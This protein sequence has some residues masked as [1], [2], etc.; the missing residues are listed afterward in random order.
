MTV[1]N[2]INGRL[3]TMGTET[4]ERVGEAIRAL[5]YR[6]DISARGLRRSKLL[7]IGMIIV[8]ESP[9]YLADGYT[10]QIV[11]GLGNF[12][13]ERGYT[14]QLEGV[15]ARALAKSSL[16]QGLRTDGLCLMLSGK[17]AVKRDQMAVL[18]ELR[19]PL[20]IFLESIGATDLDACCIVAEDR[21]GGRLLAQHLIERGAKRTV[22]LMP[23]LNYWRALYARF[24]GARH[25]YASHRRTHSLKL[26]DCG[27]GSVAAAQEALA[28][29]IDRCGM[30][31]AV[32]GAN[33]QAGIAAL[34]LLRS[35]GVKVPDQV[36][37]T[38]FNAFEF[39]DFSRPLL[40]SVKSP[41]YEMGKIGGWELL[42]RLNEGK[43]S[44]SR[45]KLPVRIMSGETT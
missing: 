43:F 30:P 33:D 17:G 26:V 44:Q 10:T 34:N 40:T 19:Q 31:D 45:R 7:S 22:M 25:T 1:S 21:K 42:T 6:P 11:S 8:D 28:A 24:E 36:R 14:L 37:V 18:R 3:D 4:Q 9:H 23:T 16:I 29:E 15:R 12:L 41:G 35:R 13:N 20:V 5:N 32:M 27:D 2:Y 39:R 38:G